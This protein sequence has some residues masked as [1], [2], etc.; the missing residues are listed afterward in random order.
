MTAA[1]VIN[2]SLVVALQSDVPNSVWYGKDVSYVHFRVFG[3]KSFIHVSKDERSEL[4]AKTKQCIFI[5]Y[6]LDE[7][8]YTL[9]DSIEKKLMIS[10]DIIST[11]NQTLKIL[12]KQRW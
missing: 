8:D 6:G 12:T 9:Y 1:H 7:F 3:C 11:K 5:R 10:H 2:L 4:D